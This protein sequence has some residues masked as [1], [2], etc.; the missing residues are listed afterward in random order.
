[1]MKEADLCFTSATKL[2]SMLDRK[3]VSAVELTEAY[4]SRIESC[5]EL[6][7]AF[8]T[9]QIDVAL[10]EA[11][12]A[13]NISIDRRGLLHGLPIGVK[14]C[15]ATKGLRTTFS[16]MAYRDH[17]PDHDHLIVEREKAAGAIILGKLNT[18][19]FTMASDTCTSPVFGSTRNPWNLNWCPGSSSGGSGAALAA[20]LCA[21]ADGSDIGGSVRNP[22]AWCH[23]VGHRPTTWLIPDVPGPRP[24]HNMNT[25]GPM[26]RTVEDVAL[27]LSATAGPDIRCPVPLSSP[28][29]EGVPDLHKDLKGLRIGWSGDLGSIAVDPSIL[30]GFDRQR[31]V[32]SDLGCVI[33]PHRLDI[34]DV[35][36]IY[37]ILAYQRV[38]AEVEPVFTTQPERLSL[39]LVDRYEWAQRLT[40]SDR[41]WAEN[42]RLKLW[43]QIVSLFEKFDVLVWPNDAQDPCAFDAPPEDQVKDWRF[44]YLAPM[45]NLPAITV[46]CGFSESGA[47]RG[48]QILATPGKDKLVIQVAH[49][50]EQSTQYGLGLRPSIQPH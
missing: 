7:N 17:V 20:G 39:S 1:M 38:N 40:E 32:F 26:G 37:N 8:V 45:L 41:V 50:F 43:R 46:P 22:A 6:L 47:P 34:S 42:G 27:F 9:L 23:I 36:S 25:P 15:F 5:N 30:A 11:R 44:L 13:D 16:C 18:P 21:L 10:A 31:D 33:S 2:R 24:W 12:H 14:D 3:D 48:V 28:F 29:P 35:E 49:A 4:V 19:E